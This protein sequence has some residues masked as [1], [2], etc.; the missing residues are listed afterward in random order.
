MSLVAADLIPL[1]VFLSSPGDVREERNIAR[2]VLEELPRQPLLRGKVSIETVAWDDPEAP[3]PLVAGVTPQVSVN[4]FNRKPSQCDLTIVI[5]WSRLGTALP[6]DVL[7][8][9]G[10]RYASGTEWELEDASSA[11]KDVFVYHRTQTP[12]ISITDPD[13]AAKQQ[14]YN[15]VQHFLRRF[16]NADGSIAGGY[17]DYETPDAF[18]QLFRKHLEKYL[19]GKLDIEQ[20]SEIDQQRLDFSDELQSAETLVGRG[21]VFAALDRFEA[22]HTSGYFRLTAAAGLGKTTLAA[23]VAQRRAAIP[24]FTSVTRGRTRAEQCLNHLSAEIIARFKLRYDRLPTRAGEDP[25]FLKKL[26]QEAVEKTGKPV[27]FVV[28][29]LDESDAIPGRNPLSLPSRLPHK[30]FCFVTQRPG[31]ALIDTDPET[32]IVDYALTWDSPMQRQDVLAFLEREVRRPE[33]AGALHKALPGRESETIVGELARLSEGNFMYLSYVLHDI[34]AGELALE[35]PGG[36]PALPRGLRGYYSSTWARIEALAQADG[37]QN[38]RTLYRPVIGLLAVAR[39]PISVAWLSD[40]SGCDREDINNPVLYRL[41]RFLNCDADRWRILHRSFSDFLQDTLDLAARH[42]A[43]ARFYAEPASWVKHE[44]Y[45]SRHLTAHLAAAGDLSGILRLFDDGT[46][47]ENQVTEDPTGVRYDTDLHHAYSLAARADSEATARGR[48]APALAHE[49]KH[50]LILSTL[51]D[52]WTSI[53][54][55][56]IVTLLH[57]GVLSDVQALGLVEKMDSRVQGRV[58]V[59]LVPAL[60]QPLLPRAVELARRSDP[61]QHAEALL[62]L[63]ELTSGER[64][65]EL[66]DEAL[67]AARAVD[68]DMSKASLL[69]RTSAGLASEVREACITEARALATA[70]KDPLT[71]ASRLAPLLAYVPD[72]VELLREALQHARTAD[73]DKATGPDEIDDNDGTDETNRDETLTGIVENVPPEH[74]LAFA[75]EAIVVARE[76]PDSWERVRALTALITEVPEAERTSIKAAALET[77]RSLGDTNEKFDRLLQL[78]AAHTAFERDALLAEAEANVAQVSDPYFRATDLLHLAGCVSEARAQSYVERALQIIRDQ[79]QPA[80]GLDVLTSAVTRIEGSV[81]ETLLQTARTMVA[82][83]PNRFARVRGLIAVGEAWSGDR[84]RSFVREAIAVP[85][86][87]LAI[88]RPPGDEVNRAELLATLAAELQGSEKDL[89]LREVSSLLQEGLDAYERAAVLAKLLPA[90]DAPERSATIREIRSQVASLEHPDQRADLLIELLRYAPKDER[91]HE[92]DEA[93]AQARSIAPGAFHL[94]G[95]FDERTFAVTLARSA[96]VMGLPSL[97]ILRLALMAPESRRSEL[98]AEALEGV[99]DLPASSQ[100]DVLRELAPHLSGTQVLD[101]MDRYEMLVRDPLR[102]EFLRWLE[103]HLAESEVS[104]QSESPIGGKGSDASAE[105]SGDASGDHEAGGGRVEF[106]LQS[107]APGDLFR[108]NR[109]GRQAFDIEFTVADGV[110]EEDKPRIQR[111]IVRSFA[112]TMVQNSSADDLL[113][114]AKDGRELRN[115]AWAAT[116]GLLLRRLCVTDSFNAA[117]QTARTTW[118]EGLPPMVTSLLIQ[119]AP[120]TERET[121]VAT[122]RAS[123]GQVANPASRAELWTLLIP[124]LDASEWPQAIQDLA[125]VVDKMGVSEVSSLLEQLDVEMLPPAAVLPFIQRVLRSTAARRDLLKSVRRMLPAI[126]RIGGTSIT[127]S[128]PQVIREAVARVR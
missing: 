127:Q 21:D 4:R 116:I 99:F 62:A 110:A 89:T 101:V 48:P 35:E 27:W 65:T 78:S 86:G 9:D 39:E 19:R 37:A 72:A 77:L 84:M 66:L 106:R 41:R 43:V 36:P 117:L 26:L 46:W 98:I 51:A 8:R 120:A 7:K 74:R 3:T 85:A 121:L 42:A 29:A 33:I 13:L 59:T 96:D 53:P 105:A 87:V 1:S 61:E 23:A 63:S 124:Y 34:R 55:H 75:R 82:G 128:L 90:L 6:P 70:A 92:L 104:G 91:E 50:A 95:R 52:Q 45:A 20:A 79:L 69:C 68:D 71:R 24:F 38:W 31:S 94:S 10:S 14:Q 16:H 17:N 108:L 125:G 47:Y 44:G 112:P 5:L 102:Q 114:V 57:V 103:E 83:M 126:K 118:G 58:L 60:S 67:K 80:Q 122:A 54:A 30:V 73:T 100:R 56:T 12:Q 109:E 22:S 15:A 11:Q 32:P 107:L 40:L 115:G 88:G 119:A 93:L 25:S 81:K 2:E 18:R 111:K 49:I 113:A 97:A 64:R 123:A 28:D 76:L